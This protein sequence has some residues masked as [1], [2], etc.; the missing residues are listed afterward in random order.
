[1]WPDTQ[2]SDW[3]SNDRVTAYGIAGFRVN[4]LVGLQVFTVR[5]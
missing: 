5:F 2:Y 4:N 1:M 3:R